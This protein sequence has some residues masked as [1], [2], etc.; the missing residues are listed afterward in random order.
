[1][2]DKMDEWL[3]QKTLVNAPKLT[4]MMY[5]P[6]EHINKVMLYGENLL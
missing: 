5:L 2:N 6:K 1:M 3:R 4:G